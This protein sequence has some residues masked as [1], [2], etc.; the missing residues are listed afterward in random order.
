MKSTP[1]IHENS[2]N[3]TKSAD[4]AKL[5]SNLHVDKGISSRLRDKKVIGLDKRKDYSEV[6]MPGIEPRL[7]HASKEERRS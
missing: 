2:R 1:V 4:P 3:P 6:L 7:F 5:I